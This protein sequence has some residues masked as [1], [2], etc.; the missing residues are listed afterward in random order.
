MEIEKAVLSLP[1]I[2]DFIVPGMQVHNADTGS[3]S[4]VP[5]AFI[6]RRDSTIDAA[7][8]MTHLHQQLSDY[9]IPRELFFK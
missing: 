8:I 4:E 2:A 1:D 3:R 5:W 9:K 6:S 7:V